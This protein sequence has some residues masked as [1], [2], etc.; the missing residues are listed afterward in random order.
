[1][2]ESDIKQERGTE[3]QKDRQTQ[4]QTEADRRMDRRMATILRH[5][6]TRETHGLQ[7][8]WLTAVTIW[9][10]FLDPRPLAKADRSLNDHMAPD[11][12]ILAKV[13]A[14]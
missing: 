7:A 1:M 8:R 5:I 11:T 9:R 14:E 10:C 13:W 4:T 2:R 6:I 3:I 12:E